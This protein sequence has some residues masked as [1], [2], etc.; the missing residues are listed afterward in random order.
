MWLDASR[1]LQG[2]NALSVELLY[3]ADGE[4]GIAQMASRIGELH[5]LCVRV[6]L[7]VDLEPGQTMPVEGDFVGKYDFAHFFEKLAR[8][9]IICQVYGTIVGNEPNLKAENV[10]GGDGGKG[11][12][13]TVLPETQLTVR[14][15]SDGTIGGSAGCN[16]YRSPYAVDG[17]TLSF[18]P[19]ATTR[20]ACP[21]PVM[22]QEQAFLAALQP[23]T[24]FSL[25]AGQLTLVGESGST[26]AVLIASI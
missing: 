6:L 15:G 14:F 8:D 2:R 12:V 5:A 17:D 23:T 19:F 22:D 11:G 4:P 13:T 16:T 21:T 7:P 3:A 18:G 9:P 1:D 25:A 20:M 24:G 10:R 26:Q